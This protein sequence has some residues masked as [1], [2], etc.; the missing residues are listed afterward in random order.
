MTTFPFARAS[1]SIGELATDLD[2]LSSELS[3]VLGRFDGMAGLPIDAHM[4]HLGHVISRTND[5]ALSMSE[6]S[7]TCLAQDSYDQALAAADTPEKVKLAQAFARD[8]ARLAAAGSVP[9]SQADAAAALAEELAQQREEALRVH[10]AATA[11]TCFDVPEDGGWTPPGG[12]GAET[13]GDDD[14]GKRPDIGG[15]V[16][17]GYNDA[18]EENPSD[19][20]PPADTPV[21]APE[22]STR[23]APS[24][25][26]SEIT[27]AESWFSVTPAEPVQAG[28]TLSSDTPSAKALTSPTGTYTP[29]PQVPTTPNQQTVASPSFMQPTQQQSAPRSGTAA[30]PQAHPQ[31]QTRAA[32]E[33]REPITDAGVAAVAATST[34]HSVSTAPTAVAPTAPT[35][36][37]STTPTTPTAPT[38]PASSATPPG[39][40]PG[41][42]PGMAPGASQQG[43]ATKPAPKI[44]AAQLEVPDELRETMSV[45]EIDLFEQALRRDADQPIRDVNGNLVM[46]PI[47]EGA[48]S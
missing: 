21:T 31:A 41:V 19:T 3:A 47:V 38:A 18:D 48:R 27:A 30:V 10:E 16:G 22:S 1:A 12:E 42:A 37:A 28:T 9:W 44:V 2:T 20:T 45:E 43:Q 46:H 29:A 8:M 40:A 39:V 15:E 7:D 33:R 23:T 17:G 36:P 6:T 34:P 35:A 32:E 4:A 5:L 11:T 26:P 24:T 13:E 25:S 14:K